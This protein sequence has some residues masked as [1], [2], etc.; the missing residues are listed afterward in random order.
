MFCNIIA[1]YICMFR[2]YYNG[3]ISRCSLGDLY[4]GNSYSYFAENSRHYPCDRDQT[5][6]LV[7]TIQQSSKPT[8]VMGVTSFFVE[9]IDVQLKW[10]LRICFD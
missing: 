1:E 7:K 5:S 10:N 6:V 4:N 9:N 3:L 8:Q 2:P